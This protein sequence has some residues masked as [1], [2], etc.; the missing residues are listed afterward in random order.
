MLY[1]EIEKYY[2]DIRYRT[3]YHIF[4]FKS[5]LDIQTEA[6]YRILTFK[7]IF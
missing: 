6:E 4:T 1:F 2:F 5:Y 7:I 3:E